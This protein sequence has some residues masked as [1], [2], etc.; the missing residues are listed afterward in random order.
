MGERHHGFGLAATAGD[1]VVAGGE[2]PLVAVADGRVGLDDV[3]STGIRQVQRHGH[4]TGRVRPVGD[5][6]VIQRATA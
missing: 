3:D 5:S 6:C 4:P 1:P 2:I